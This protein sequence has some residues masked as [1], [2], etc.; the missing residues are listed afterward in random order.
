M[1][2]VWAPGLQAFKMMGFRAP[3][4][5]LWGPLLRVDED[6][7]TFLCTQ[8]NRYLYFQNRLTLI[9]YANGGEVTE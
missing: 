2:I 8:E 6:E 1:G 3:A 4:T 5:S 7:T 9:N